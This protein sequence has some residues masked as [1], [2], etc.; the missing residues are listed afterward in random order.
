MPFE[1]RIIAIIKPFRLSSSGS[2]AK[3]VAVRRASS[4]VSISIGYAQVNAD[5]MPSWNL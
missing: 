1:T 4:R 2:L 5:V 3:F